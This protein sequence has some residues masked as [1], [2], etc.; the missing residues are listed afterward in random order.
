MNSASIFGKFE[1][2]RTLY[3]NKHP[4]SYSSGEVTVISR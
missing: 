4:I 3:K 1:A 2:A